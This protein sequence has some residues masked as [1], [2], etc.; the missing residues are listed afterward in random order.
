MLFTNQAQTTYVNESDTNFPF[1]IGV[2]ICQ[3]CAEPHYVS[4]HFDR[5]LKNNRTKTVLLLLR[6][7]R[8]LP[9]TCKLV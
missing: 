7:C 8:R 1:W 3:S 5:K 2:W 6:V 9:W 4:K